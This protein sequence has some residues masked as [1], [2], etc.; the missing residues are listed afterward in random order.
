MASD[1]IKKEGASPEAVR[2]IGL[3]PAELAAAFGVSRYTVRQWRYAGCPCVCINSGKCS[4]GHRFRY[5]L[6]QVR[7]WLESRTAGTAGKEVKA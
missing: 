4:T 3:T 6:Q 2:Q 1:R 5:G 7:A